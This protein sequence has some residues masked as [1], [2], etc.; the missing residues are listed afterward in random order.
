VESGI[1]GSYSLQHSTTTAVPADKISNETNQNTPE[2]L[3]VR[4]QI[5]NETD[6]RDAFQPYI[7]GILLAPDDGQDV[8][9]NDLTVTDARCLCFELRI[10]ALPHEFNVLDIASLAIGWIQVPTLVRTF[11]VRMPLPQTPAAFYYK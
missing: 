2:I 7:S 6:G 5:T 10:S 9:S 8:R 4:F 1:T 3:D 11:Q